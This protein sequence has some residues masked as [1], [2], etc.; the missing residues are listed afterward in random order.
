MWRGAENVVALY[1]DE[2]PAAL[3]LFALRINPKTAGHVAGPLEIRLHRHQRTHVQVF[4]RSGR[5]IEVDFIGLA[6]GGRI[7][8]QQAGTKIDMQ[9]LAS[10]RVSGSWARQD[11][12]LAGDFVAVSLR[13]E[14]HCDQ[15]PLQQ[16]AR[17]DSTTAL[18]EPRGRIQPYPNGRWG[19]RIANGQLTAVG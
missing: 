10:E 16:S 11:R 15:G 19:D 18:R 14:F 13:I 5:R 3:T 1:E 6:V 12:N 8:D 2:T 9:D 4:I 17:R 7:Q